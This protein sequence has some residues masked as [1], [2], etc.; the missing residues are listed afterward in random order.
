MPWTLGVEFKDYFLPGQLVV[1]VHMEL[2]LPNTDYHLSSVR[3]PK[4]QT[5]VI[6]H[7][8]PSM[9]SAVPNV[10]SAGPTSKEVPNVDSAV[11]TS[12]KVPKEP[13][14]YGFQICGSNKATFPFLGQDGLEDECTLLLQTISPQLDEEYDTCRE[15]VGFPISEECIPD[16]N[17]GLGEA[18]AESDGMTKAA[19]E[20]G[21]VLKGKP[22]LRKKA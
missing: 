17:E 11:P 5:S 2:G 9:D 10:D 7:E 1:Y 21:R 18:E 19:T 14:V 13:Y 22:L 6:T 15:M 4:L 20:K 3:W 16:A 12:N 8:V